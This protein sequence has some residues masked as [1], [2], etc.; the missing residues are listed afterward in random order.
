MKSAEGILGVMKQASLEPSN[1]TYTVLLCAYAKA[2]DK[3]ALQRLIT[4]CKLKDVLL[5]DRD[6]LEVAYTAAVN[7]QDHLV[8]DVS[9][10]VPLSVGRGLKNLI[11]PI[12]Y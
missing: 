10:A 3:E 7:N 9:A 8:D 1:E 11:S 4:D 2:G 5:A 12:I 6:V